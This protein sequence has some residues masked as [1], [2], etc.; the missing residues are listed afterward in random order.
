[1]QILRV[2]SSLLVEVTISTISE[3]YAETLI[4]VVRIQFLTQIHRNQ[5]EDPPLQWKVL[6]LCRVSVSVSLVSC[7]PSNL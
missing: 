3:I 5:S 6:I 2:E 4:G 1:M 7:R